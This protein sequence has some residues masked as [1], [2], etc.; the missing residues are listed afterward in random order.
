MHVLFLTEFCE[1]VFTAD[2]RAHA[3]QT[4]KS[5]ALHFVS[6]FVNLCQEL[7]CRRSEWIIS[8]LCNG[9]IQSEEIIFILHK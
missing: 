6:A 1:C 9:T 3:L 4:F 2:T 7:K 5:D 8:N